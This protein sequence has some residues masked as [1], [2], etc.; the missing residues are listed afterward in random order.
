MIGI[1]RAIHEENKDIAK[2]IPTNPET[3][4]SQLVCSPKKCCN[5]ECLEC[6]EKAVIDPIKHILKTFPEV[7]FAKW[8]VVDG[9]NKNVELTDSGENIA[10]LLQDM[11]RSSLKSHIYN[12]FRQHSELKCLKSQFRE[13]E[14]ICS[15]DFS[16]NYGNKQKHEIQSA[17]FGNEAFTLFTAACYYKPTG[18][19]NEKV[20]ASRL[21]VHSVVIVSND[22]TMHQRNIAFSCNM[23]LLDYLK[24]INPKLKTVYFWSDGYASQF[25]SKYVLRSLSFYSF[26]LQVF[27]DYG[28]AHH[29]IGPHDGTGGKIKRKVYQHVSSGKVIIT[30]ATNLQH[31]QMN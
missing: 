26:W 12:F 9:H 5:E 14:V 18:N 8:V 10:E 11:V 29:F 17:Y 15:V 16:K 2:S 19:E 6:P 22:E 20:V 13:E 7:I 23:K 3:F 30:D 28:E 4:I 25:R 21:V 31:T 27:W 24:S 1:R